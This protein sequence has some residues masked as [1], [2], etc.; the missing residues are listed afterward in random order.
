MAFKF[1]LAP[2]DDDPALQQ[3]RARPV[4]RGRSFADKPVRGCVL[5]SHVELVLGSQLDKAHGR[6][7]RGL[8]DA[9]GVAII[10]L[11]RL[12]VG[13]NIFQRHQPDIASLI[14]AKRRPRRSAPRRAAMAT[15][16][17]PGRLASPSLRDAAKPRRQTRRDR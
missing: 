12:D 14:F 2:S 16:S 10:V 7:R 6:T 8:G 3:E 9:L 5:S 1:A 4:D 11:S 15:I 13:P 17:Q